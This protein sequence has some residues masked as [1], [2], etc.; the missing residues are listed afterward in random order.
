MKKLTKKYLTELTYEIIGGA[1]EVHKALG[2]GLLEQAYESCFEYELKL[3]G[4]KVERQQSVP[5]FYKGTSL[6]ANLRYDLLVENCI[7]IELKAVENMNPV[8]EAQILTYMHLLNIPKGIL[9]NFFCTNLF[10]DGQQTFVN[11][12]FRTL[13]DV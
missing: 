3:R 12:F 8:F 2:P 7:V 5:I 1:I 6:D 10:K 9:L 4:L 13:P 11:E